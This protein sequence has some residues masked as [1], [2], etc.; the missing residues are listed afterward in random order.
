MAKT[1]RSVRSCRF[2]CTSSRRNVSRAKNHLALLTPFW[3]NSPPPSPQWGGPAGRG[4]SAVVG[5]SVGR[6]S[7][8]RLFSSLMLILLGAGLTVG[9]LK[10]H[11]VRTDN[12]F[13]WFHKSSRHWIDTYADVRGWTS[14]IWRKHEELAKVV[15]EQGRGDLIPHVDPTAVLKSLVAPFEKSRQTSPAESSRSSFDSRP[16]RVDPYRP[17]RSAETETGREHQ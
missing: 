15:R 3:K 13:V 10:Y 9:S 14:D 2:N 1:C 12:G 8:R 6:S 5:N 4:R 16:H 17:R 11:L 7:M